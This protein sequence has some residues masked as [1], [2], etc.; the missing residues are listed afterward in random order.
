M[1]MRKRNRAERK[2]DVLDEMLRWCIRITKL[3]SMYFSN[4]NTR[5]T[6]NLTACYSHINRLCLSILMFYLRGTSCIV[7]CNARKR[8]SAGGKKMFLTKNWGRSY[9][10][11]IRILCV[12][13]TKLRDLHLT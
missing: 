7:R 6:S 3:I 10:L 1:C 5:L 8:N 11:E 9:V 13:G 2:K 4:E 12:S